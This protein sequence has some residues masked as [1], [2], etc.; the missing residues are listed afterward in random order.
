MNFLR[1]GEANIF[2]QVSDFLNYVTTEAG[3]FYWSIGVLALMII[4]FVVLLILT[5]K[6]YEVTL[7][8]CVEKLNRYFLTKPF[9][10]EEN[11]VEFNLKM[12]KVPKV[13]R[14]HWQMYML[15]REDSP[16][17][18]INVDSCIE[19]PL[20]TSS[21]EKNIKNF[22]TFTIL[23]VA[24]TLLFGFGAI[25]S[26]SLA[27]TE[28]IFQSLIVP[29]IIIFFY[30]MFTLIMNAW[31]NAIYFDLYD[32][33][34]LFERNLNKAV[35]TLPPYVDYEI[36]FTKKE[37][38][39]GIPV[40]Q[41]YLEKRALLE[42]EELEKARLNA[43]ACE[44]Y[45]FGELGI[46]GSLVL[47]RAMKE[48]ET[49]LSSKRRLQTECDQIEAEKEN[50]KKNFEST[51]K[52][53]QRKL[54]ASREN[55]ESLRQQQENSTNRIEANYIRKQQSDEI[56]KQQQIE[57]DSD[58]AT[59]K[60]KEEQASLEEE[61]TKRKEEI[62][63]KRKFVE[64]AMLLEFKHYANVLYKRL[65]DFAATQSN[66]K[67][68][69]L[70]QENTDLK[71]LV[72]DMQGF[73][74]EATAPTADPAADMVQAEELA[75]EGLYEM[76][77]DEVSQTAQENHEILDQKA[78]EIKA[79]EEQE[80]KEA[81]EAAEK[82]AQ[83]T[84]Q[85]V[86]ETEFKET[87][88][89]TDDTT[90][91]GN[92]D[93]GMT[94]EATVPVEE[95]AQ[96]EEV[97]VEETPVE[98]PVVE[99]PV[100][101]PVVEAEPVVEEPV[102][103]A[104]PVVE[105]QPVVEETPAEEPVVTEAD[106]DALQKQIDEESNNLA[107]QKQEFSEEIDKTISK[108]PVEETEEVAE[109]PVEEAVEEPVEEAEEEEDNETD[110]SALTPKTVAPVRRTARRSNASARTSDARKKPSKARERTGGRSD[111]NS[112]IDAINAEM[113]NLLQNVKK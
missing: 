11:L 17:A 6:S 73:S 3:I 111:S 100:V 97:A 102:V 26:S 57:K 93:G 63:E 4:A 106:L 64:Q 89:D 86:N 22:T 39:D 70:V 21:I 83:E 52:E 9:I 46:D 8:S 32:T 66:Q 14:T 108:I 30:T 34:P 110:L 25:G 16:S 99:A 85:A 33:F 60:Y 67:L 113:Q 92:D 48:T 84:V 54:A 77:A 109:E 29:S 36:L 101:E 69:K 59:A 37:I 75:P 1:L 35:S 72:E 41:Q 98:E 80:K 51:S 2:N 20:K 79:N 91:T 88:D 96:T 104:E 45:D 28:V 42:Q 103:E 50:Y 53:Y 27:T 76:T 43:V 19:K 40:L 68:E 31:K 47:E 56:K 107:K 5:R 7:L 55:L 87:T 49:F 74:S 61:I 82:A 65:A 12:K 71:S 44:E 90:A 112:A 15:N 10:N 95:P 18:Y 58:E 105:E 62:E 38:K 81:A 78:E 24:L 23:L 94:P 13:L